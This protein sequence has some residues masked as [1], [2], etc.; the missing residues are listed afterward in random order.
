LSLFMLYFF[1]FLTAS[2]NRFDVVLSS[3]VECKDL[4]HSICESLHAQVYQVTRIVQT[5]LEA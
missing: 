4:M 3:R 1:L 2:V 5:V